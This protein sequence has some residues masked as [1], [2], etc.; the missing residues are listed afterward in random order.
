MTHTEV[1][2]YPMGYNEFKW[3]SKFETRICIDIFICLTTWTLEF[4]INRDFVSHTLKKSDRGRA[5]HN[6]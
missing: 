4:D 6:R 1:L 3:T 2:K 5:Q